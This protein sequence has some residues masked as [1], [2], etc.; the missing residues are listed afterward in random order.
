MED[1]YILYFLINPNREYISLENN[2]KKL[3]NH[4]KITDL[5]KKLVKAVLKI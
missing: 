5:A 1:F 3:V 2:D 4:K